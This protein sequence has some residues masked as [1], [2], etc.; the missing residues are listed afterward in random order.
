MRSRE[1][2]PAYGMLQSKDDEKTDDEE[3]P[4]SAAEDRSPQPYSFVGKSEE[5]EHDDG[6]YSTE[7][8]STS[9]DGGCEEEEANGLVERKEPKGLV[10]RSGPGFLSLGP[11]DEELDENGLRLP[12]EEAEEEERPPPSSPPSAGVRGLKSGFFTFKA[13]SDPAQKPSQSPSRPSKPQSPRK[14]QPSSP[15]GPSVRG[16][17]PG[18][19]KPH[20]A[21][22]VLGQ[23]KKVWVSGKAKAGA[24]SERDE[25]IPDENE[26]F[27]EAK[28]CVEEL[29]RA[30]EAVKAQAKAAKKTAASAELLVEAN[31]RLNESK[32]MHHSFLLAKLNYAIDLASEQIEYHQE[33]EGELSASR[34][35]ALRSA[36]E[37]LRELRASMPL[38]DTAS[39]WTTLVEQHGFPYSLI[40][41][42]L[43]LRSETCKAI[44]PLILSILPMPVS[45]THLTLPTKA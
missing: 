35:E 43:M 29:V 25:N 38:M 13:R 45:Y 5:E 22:N 10:E 20:K 24:L 41:S 26:L 28:E 39:T 32:S 2:S 33:T 18:F 16:M 42:G 37:I 12:A 6:D 17:R 15:P 23:K 27:E 4:P 14:P 21:V 3:D 36:S 30:A 11:A 1:T 7:K 31:E 19:L 40:S 9:T 44:E 8:Y 34:V